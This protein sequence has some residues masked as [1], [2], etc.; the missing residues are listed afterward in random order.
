MFP[1]KTQSDHAFR[2]LSRATD[3]E[4]SYSLDYCALWSLGY[5]RMV[6][7][8]FNCDSLLRYSLPKSE[9]RKN[10]LPA[11]KGLSLS[12]NTRAISRKTFLCKFVTTRYTPK[13]FETPPINFYLF[14]LPAWFM[15]WILGVMSRLNFEKNWFLSLNS[16]AS[17]P[18]DSTHNNKHFR[19]SLSPF[20]AYYSAGEF[21]LV[22]VC[23]L[24]WRPF[25]LCCSSCCSNHNTFSLAMQHSSDVECTSWHNGQAQAHSTSDHIA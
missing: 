19:S 11:V 5:P 18:G 1:Q 15:W 7:G 2:A 24:S 16:L 12:L 9:K 4:Q 23:R 6:S 3:I 17:P 22:C 21:P 25:A 13:T 14:D 20:N 10:T 8:Q